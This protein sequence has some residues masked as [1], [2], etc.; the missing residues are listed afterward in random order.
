LTLRAEALAVEGDVGHAGAEG[1]VAVEPE[2]ESP[3]RGPV[4]F[5]QLQQPLEETEGAIALGWGHELAHVGGLIVRHEARQ[6]PSRM[7]T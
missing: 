3:A 7:T 4:H 2:A 5:E 6:S 1:A